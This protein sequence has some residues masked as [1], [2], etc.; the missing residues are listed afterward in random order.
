MPTPST[1]PWYRHRW[2]WILMA[3]PAIVVVA[4]IGTAVLAVE[5][6]DGV[7]ADD[8]YRQGLAINRTLAREQHAKD[9][10]VA[11]TLQFN[12]EGTRARVMLASDASAPP[13]L[14]LSLIHPTR[15]GEDQVIALA[16]AAPGVFEGAMKPPHAGKWDVKLEDRPATW[17]LEGEWHTGLAQVALGDVRR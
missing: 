1:A 13:A 9:L 12:E 16:P 6:D 4:G 11:A 10:A 17:R 14:K 15:A 7:V 3:G 2:P 8:Y 5:T